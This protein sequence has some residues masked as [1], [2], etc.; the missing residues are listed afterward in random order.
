MKMPVHEFPIGRIEAQILPLLSEN[1]NDCHREGIE[2]SLQRR[3]AFIDDRGKIIEADFADRIVI[4]GFEGRFISEPHAGFI[5]FNHGF[6][7]DRPAE[8]IALQ[9]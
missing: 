9:F 3:I 7:R 8:V 5:F 6:Q 4:R 2:E 1:F